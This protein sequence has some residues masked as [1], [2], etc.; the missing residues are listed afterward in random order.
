MDHSDRVMETFMSRWWTTRNLLVHKSW[1]SN[2]MLEDSEEDE[3]K[4]QS[5]ISAYMNLTEDG[6]V[7]K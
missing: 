3:G 4:P 6:L 5:L 1:V 2:W 7:A